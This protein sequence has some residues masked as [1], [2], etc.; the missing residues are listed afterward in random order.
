MS[1]MNSVRATRFVAGAATLC[2]IG[3]FGAVASAT[4]ISAPIN[5]G[6]A[7]AMQGVQDIATNGTFLEAVEPYNLPTTVVTNSGGQSFTFEEMPAYTATGTSPS[8]TSTSSLGYI[9]LTADNGYEPTPVSFGTYDPSSTNTNYN[10][11]VGS[12]VYTSQT[13]SVANG[14][15]GLPG[16]DPGLVT[17]NK[18]I[19]GHS[20]QVEVWDWFQLSGQDSLTTFSGATPVTLNPSTAQYAIGSFT[21]TAAQEAFT[22]SQAN[23]SAEYPLV[24]DVALWDTTVPEPAS[25]GLM[26]VGA[27]GLLLIRRRRI[28]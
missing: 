21:A 5:W 24:N 20:Y 3:A 17:L 15:N 6:T 13:I 2:V 18:L 26:V 14:G 19:A 22:F 28:A 1:M 8:Y 11:A 7:Q 4:A 27:I 23:S 9:T 12:L 10:T 16:G 25:I